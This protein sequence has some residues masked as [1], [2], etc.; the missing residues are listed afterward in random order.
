MP[1]I[2]M[3]TKVKE[4]SCIFVPGL[5]VTVRQ[6]LLLKCSHLDHQQQATSDTKFTSDLA[7]TTDAAKVQ[8]FATSE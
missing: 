6:L 7:A 5:S 8:V 1:P 4:D 3:V 2:A